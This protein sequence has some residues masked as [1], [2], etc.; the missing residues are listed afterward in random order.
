MARQCNRDDLH[1]PPAY[2]VGDV[3]IGIDFHDRPSLNRTYIS[4]TFRVVGFKRDDRDDYVRLNDLEPRD[5]EHTWFIWR[6]AKYDGEPSCIICVA[7]C[8]RDSPCEF[9]TSVLE[10]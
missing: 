10:E 1:S 6:V 4:K 2:D 3:V 7:D 9:F 5:G 8:K